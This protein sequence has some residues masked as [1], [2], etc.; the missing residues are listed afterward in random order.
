MQ[1]RAQRGLIE[2]LLKS[3]SDTSWLLCWWPVTRNASLQ[4]GA[5]NH[6]VRVVG[7]YFA[8]AG[9]LTAACQEE[10]SNQNSALHGKNIYNKF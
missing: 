8:L 10:M 4:A 2:T 5:M 3:G 6:H 9:K 1:D 7:I